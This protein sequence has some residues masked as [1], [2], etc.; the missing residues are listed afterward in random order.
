M[1]FWFFENGSPRLKICR[2]MED[3]LRL[4]IFFKFVSPFKFVLKNPTTNYRV[5][6]SRYKNKT[7]ENLW[8][9]FGVR[10]TKSAIARL[11]VPKESLEIN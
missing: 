10:R 7:L 3:C 6:E 5:E 2:S 11:L 9:N 4:Y 1:V 8:V